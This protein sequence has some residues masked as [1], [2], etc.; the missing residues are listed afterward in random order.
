M[1]ELGDSVCLKKVLRSAWD[2]YF[3][4]NLVKE[5]TSQQDRDTQQADDND[6]ETGS[7]SI[8]K[9]QEFSIINYAIWLILAKYT[10]RIL[11][12]QSDR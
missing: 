6:T 4:S 12:C 2:L 7:K 9:W 8:A 1:I 3:T 11:F 5:L 10:D